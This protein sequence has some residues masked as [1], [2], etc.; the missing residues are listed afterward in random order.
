MQARIF[1]SRELN[2]PK[3]VEREHV[4]GFQARADVHIDNLEV[5]TEVL[6]P[7]DERKVKMLAKE[8][9]E[10][11]DPSN[12][13]LTVVPLDPEAFSRGSDKPLNFVVVHGRHR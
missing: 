4:E 12:M 8:M 11:F 1:V 9:T 2:D 6:L 7:I 13:T 10:R 5:C 3:V